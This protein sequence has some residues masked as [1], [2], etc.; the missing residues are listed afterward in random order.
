MPKP[1]HLTALENALWEEGR[2]D[3]ERQAKVDQLC[4]NPRNVLVPGTAVTY[5]HATNE[6]T[7]GSPHMAS[8]AKRV[9]LPKAPSPFIPGDYVGS[10]ATCL[11]GKDFRVMQ[12]LEQADP[13]GVVMSGGQTFRFTD[14]LPR[15]PKLAYGHQALFNA[16]TS[17][18]SSF[19]PV[20][21]TVSPTGDTVVVCDRLLGITYVI[22]AKTSQI[23]HTFTIRQP[24]QVSALPAA[25]I[26]Q[27]LLVANHA[28]SQLRA[29]DLGT[30]E[31]VGLPVYYGAVS[32]VIAAPT[33]G[34]FALICTAPHFAVYFVEPHSLDQIAV[35][36]LTGRPFSEH[37]DPFDVLAVSPDGRHLLTLSCQEAP[38]PESPMI[39]V[40]DVETLATVRRMLLRPDEK[41]AALAFAVDNPFYKTR[42]TVEEALIELGYLSADEL[43]EK[44]IALD[45]GAPLPASVLERIPPAPGLDDLAGPQTTWRSPEPVPAEPIEYPAS[46]ERLIAD[47]I[48][49]EYADV[50]GLGLQDEPEA[51]ARVAASAGEAKAHLQTHRAVEVVLKELTLTGDVE[52][53]ITRDMVDEWLQILE[54]QEAANRETEEE[55]L[56]ILDELPETCPECGAPLFGSYICPGCGLDVPEAIKAKGLD[57][58][59]NEQ[60]GEGTVFE[61][62]F[63]LPGHIFLADADRRRVIELDKN[64]AIAWQMQANGDSGTGLDKLLQKPVDALRLANGNSLILDRYGRQLFEVTADG[65]PY[66]EW[67]RR[68]G[69]L[70]EP[71]RVARTE[72][73]ETLVV[74]RAAHL[75]RRVDAQGKPKSPYGRGTPGIG[76][77]ELC[78]PTDIQILPNGHQLICDS[79]NNRVI[80]VADGELV[81]QFGNPQNVARGG[82]GGGAAALN[83][84]QRAFRLASGKTVILDSGNHRIVLLDRFGTLRWEFDTQAP[85]PEVAIAYPIGMAAM[86]RGQLA[87]WDD[88]VIV[89][90]DDE[91][92]V[93]WAD[94][95]DKLDPNPRMQRGANGDVAR[96]WKVER[97]TPD[98]PAILAAKAEQQA[99]AAAVR[100]ARKA[101]DEG[102]QAE[103]IRLLKE[104]A[105]RRLAAMKAEKPWRVDMAAVRRLC[106]ELRDEL[107]EAVKSRRQEQKAAPPPP[108]PPP[109][110]APVRPVAEAKAVPPPPDDTLEGTDRLGVDRP[111]IDLLVP[112]RWGNWVV[113]IRRDHQ[114]HWLWGDGALEKPHSAELHDGHFVLIAD[115][116]H[117]R[118]V[119]VDTTTDTIVWKSDPK[120]GLNGPRH[121]QRLEDGNVLIADQHN[122]RLIEVTPDQHVAWE[123]QDPYGRA[124][125][126]CCQRLEDGNTLFVDMAG[127][128]VREI[129]AGGR[130]VWRYDE[131][132]APEYAVRLP[133]HD[134]LIADSRNNRVVEIT[135]DGLMAWDYQGSG[136]RRLAQP[137]GVARTAD[138]GTLI[139][140]GTGRLILEIGIS[141]QLLWRANIKANVALTRMVR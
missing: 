67:P 61:R 90:I 25:C 33:G 32:N 121:A 124:A 115:T 105:A 112:L 139:T 132:L 30:G 136:W 46:V 3:D 134:T 110:A 80:E 140:Q 60:L 98:D 74:D 16:Y 79:G 12:D 100:A 122:H 128:T 138:G 9:A 123:W 18:N 8:Y 95:L 114:V 28:Q 27:R 81:W 31:E 20:D 24:G 48:E 49:R 62:A 43:L 94:R 59:L 77:G 129:D 57:A 133:N 19:G 70:V 11:V 50:N 83:A 15:E 97:L 36:G 127:S 116:G 7:I 26:Q 64:G 93:L 21:L 35:V 55:F 75:I 131:L 107:L 118:V 125:P 41:P 87:Y 37:G 66:W 92:G 17:R 47:F 106:E 78:F 99:R 85:P 52:V 4:R 84:P 40:I 13:D 101:A 108:P 104:E 73:G 119:D 2:L 120:L 54:R 29:F 39:S 51:K 96:L 102:R 53:V 38:E 91:G 130:D 23:R 65:E 103:C 88:S 68:A 76:Q 72:W 63:L 58:F 126:V 22:D 42:Y 137:L 135:P 56:E 45:T 5:D 141:R 86:D 1:E 117:Q 111:A 82:A 113:W 14:Q 10:T 34:Y 44:V 89:Q 71:V 6:V 109:A 69:A